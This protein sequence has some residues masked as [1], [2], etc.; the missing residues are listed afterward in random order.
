MSKLPHFL[1]SQL[2]DSGE[3]VKP[4]ALVALYSK[5]DS[6]YSFLLRGYVNP[7][8][9]VWLERLILLILHNGS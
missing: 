6:W 3:T 8:A 2:T 1:D 4:Y 7:R 9:I 5:E